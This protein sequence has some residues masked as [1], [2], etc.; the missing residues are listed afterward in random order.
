MSPNV[1]QISFRS[2]VYKSDVKI[3]ESRFLLFMRTC[4]DEEF[5][6]PQWDE[7]NAEDCQV[8]DV[9]PVQHFEEFVYSLMFLGIEF[10]HR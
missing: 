10:G 5:D 3:I 7:L 2:P 8:P 6:K 9:G 1:L 4:S